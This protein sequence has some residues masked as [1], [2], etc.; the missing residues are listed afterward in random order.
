MERRSQRMVACS[1][2]AHADSRNKVQSRTPTLAYTQCVLRDGESLFPAYKGGGRRR[3]DRQR[4]NRQSERAQ[5][6]M[7]PITACRRESEGAAREVVLCIRR[8]YRRLAAGPGGVAR[9]LYG[10]HFTSELPPFGLG[11]GEELLPGVFFMCASASDISHV[12]QATLASPAL[13][14]AT[15]PSPAFH[16]QQ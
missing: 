14:G 13:R 15:V 2:P 4:G 7:T 10:P 11:K 12:M 5:A 1:A 6:V 8:R 3:T 9:A 16:R